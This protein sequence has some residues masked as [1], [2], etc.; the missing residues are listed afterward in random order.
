MAVALEVAELAEVAVNRTR[1]RGE[2]GRRR[3]KGV[4]EAKARAITKARQE[5]KHGLKKSY[6]KINNE[7][8]F[9]VCVVVVIVIVFVAL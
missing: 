3:N 1:T 5:G 4:E 6:L 2:E 7:T 8:A 9:F